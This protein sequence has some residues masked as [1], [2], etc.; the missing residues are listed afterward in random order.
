MPSKNDS[1]NTSLSI[2][3]ITV[4]EIFT[5]LTEMSYIYLIILNCP[6]L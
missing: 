1:L 6:D 2:L 4:E 3:T 5:I